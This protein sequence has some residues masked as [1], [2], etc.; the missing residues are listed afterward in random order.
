MAVMVHSRGSGWSPELYQATFDRA[1]PDTA[2][3]PAGL[4]A[5]FATPAGNGEWQVI[6]VWD[7]EE[8]FRHFL[9]KTVLPVAK[10]LGAPP[11]DSA[12]FEIYNYLIP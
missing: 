5:H 3:P 7:S 8:A 2:N 10:E 9:E 4:L 1:I 11:F 12:A 6:D